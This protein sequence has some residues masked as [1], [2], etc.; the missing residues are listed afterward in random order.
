MINLRLYCIGQSLYNVY[1]L[2]KK[3]YASFAKYYFDRTSSTLWVLFIKRF[4]PSNKHGLVYRVF[5]HV[6]NSAI[7][8]LKYYSNFLLNVFPKNVFVR[9]LKQ[10]YKS[11]DADKIILVDHRKTIS[12]PYDKNNQAL[13]N[14]KEVGQSNWIPRGKSY[15]IYQQENLR[16]P[17]WNSLYECN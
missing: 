8:R 4:F 5:L 6:C 3:N 7:N 9:H 14:N 17:T 1:V 11:L 15:N 2:C 16:I 12:R 13:T 10:A